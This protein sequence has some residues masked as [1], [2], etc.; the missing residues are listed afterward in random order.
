MDNNYL[1]KKYIISFFILLAVSAVGILFFYLLYNIYSYDNHIE[2]VFLTICLYGL[3]GIVNI[4]L[5]KKYNETNNL[6]NMNIIF[7]K[8]TNIIFIITA[9]VSVKEYFFGLC[10]GYIVIFCYIPISVIICC[11]YTIHKILK[12]KNY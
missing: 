10:I 12:L 11:F 3:Y 6:K 7:S 8:L 2:D 4:V 1:V 5:L 9:I